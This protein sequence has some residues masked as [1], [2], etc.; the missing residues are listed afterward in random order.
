MAFPVTRHTL[1]QRLAQGGGGDDWQDFL[2][3]YWGVVCRYAKTA[4][5]LSFEDSEDVAADV[6]EIILSAKLLQRWS[7]SRTAKLRTL[8]CSVVRNVLN[9]RSRVAQG[10]ERVVRDHLGQLDRYQPRSSSDPEDLSAEQID[11]FSAAWAESLVQT[12]ID[13]VF[14]EY[15]KSKKADYFRVLYGRLCEDISMSEIASSLRIPV[16]SADNFFRHARA[17]LTERLEE[18]VRSHVCRYCDPEE[19][20]EEFTLEWN[21]LKECLQRYGGLEN[22]IRAIYSSDQPAFQHQW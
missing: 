18:L 4:G 1:I 17:R 8:I 16:T 9:N 2:R 22:A 19:V 15:S 7:E 5:Q 13:S 20:P 11:A 3:D 12:A 21:R 6:F 10:R 14:T